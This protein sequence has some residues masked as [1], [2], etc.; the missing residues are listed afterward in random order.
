MAQHPLNGLCFKEVSTVVERKL[1]LIGFL[2]NHGEVKFGMSNICS[3]LAQ[4][5]SR[6][7]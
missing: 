1:W 5:Q 6:E 7:F 4:L 3:E 2:D